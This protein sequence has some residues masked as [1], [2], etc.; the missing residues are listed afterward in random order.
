[1]ND[2]FMWELMIL[3]DLLRPLESPIIS[4]CVYFMWELTQKSQLIGFYIGGL[5][6]LMG[7]PEIL[8]IFFLGCGSLDLHSIGR[9]LFVT[10][11][12][13]GSSHTRISFLLGL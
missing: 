3:G 13:M 10:C 5:V 7:F 1:M 11:F 4:K 8:R 6:R 12:G 9:F 2:R